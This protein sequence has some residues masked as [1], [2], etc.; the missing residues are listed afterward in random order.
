M[1]S[2]LSRSQGPFVVNL[3]NVYV[4]GLVNLGVERDGQLRAQD[5]NMDITFSDINLKFENLGFMGSIFQGILNSVGTFLFDSI[6]P[7]VLKEA[8][9]KIRE[10]VNKNI[11]NLAG[12][13]RFPNS[14]SPLDMVIADARS[15]VRQMEFDPMLMTDHTHVTQ[16]YRADLTHTWVTGLSS[17]YRVGNIS[18]SVENHTL[19]ADFEVGTQ[20][21][22]GQTQWDISFVAGLMSR[23]GTASFSV[24]YI[25]V[26]VIL[27]QPLDTRKRPECRSVE[28]ELGNIQ[29]RC[30]GGGI[31]DYAVEFMVNILPN[32]LRFQIMDAIEGPI[33]SKIQEKLNE[34]DVD[35]VIKSKLPN[36]KGM[37]ITDIPLAHLKKTLPKQEILDEDDFW[38]FD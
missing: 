6:K 22:E 33:Q 24:D 14:L 30:D 21:L 34:I 26:R 10:E 15:K 37:D 27:A 19:I 20:K 17:F 28:L 1:S 23:A 11:E 38:K 9:T 2:W 3:T 16:F 4:Q 7:F 12:E 32:L 18:L 5:I 13:M 29:A 8:Y 25:N 35:Y 31:V 36:L